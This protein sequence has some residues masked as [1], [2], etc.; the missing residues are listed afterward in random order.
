MS[1]R[2][3]ILAL[4]STGLAA[5]TTDASGVPGDAVQLETQTLVKHLGGSE[6]YHERARLLI[7]DPDEWEQR[8]PLIAESEG[9]APAVDFDSQMVLVSA[10][11]VRNTSGYAI[12]IEGVYEDGEGIYVEVREISPGPTCGSFGALTA[13]VSAVAIPRRDGHVSWVEL[14]D[15]TSC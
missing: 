1:S 11:G 15:T 7:R 8:W 3:L 2:I 4:A 13:P 6:P 14:S 12:T 5:C 9:P 10:M